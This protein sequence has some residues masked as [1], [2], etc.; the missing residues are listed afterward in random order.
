MKKQFGDRNSAILLFFGV[1]KTA[2]IHYRSGNR[3]E[4]NRDLLPVGLFGCCFLPLVS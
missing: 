1:G 3:A 2:V 4:T